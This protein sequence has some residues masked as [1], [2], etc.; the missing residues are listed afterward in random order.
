MEWS[1]RFWWV[2]LIG[3]VSGQSW[4]AWT[5]QQVGLN[6]GRQ[7]AYQSLLVLQPRFSPQGWEAFLIS[8]SFGYRFR[9]AHFLHGTLLWFD[10]YTPRRFIQYRLL[11]R[12][13]W[14]INS[15]FSGSLTLEQRWE[16]SQLREALFRPLLRGRWRLRRHFWLILIEEMLWNHWTLRRPWRVDLRQQ[17]FWVVLAF[18]RQKP[19]SVEIGY[20]HF[21]LPQSAPRH[22]LWLALRWNVTL[23]PPAPRRESGRA[24]PADAVQS[25]PPESPAESPLR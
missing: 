9:P 6:W 8:G 4:G 20:I 18:P 25:P 12:W 23:S 7:G 11:E 15:A 19:W 22:R 2:S 1:R 21:A 16:Q 24:D 3:V 14:Q 5:L 10:A 13:Q 17:R